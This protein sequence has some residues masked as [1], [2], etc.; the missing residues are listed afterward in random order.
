MDPIT[1]GQAK[2]HTDQKVLE[3]QEALDV[4]T[5]G[6]KW[7]NQPYGNSNVVPKITTLI[8]CQDDETPDLVSCTASVDGE[9]WK[10]NGR[11]WKVEIAGS[12]TAQF[13]MN[14]PAPLETKP[15]QSLCAWVYIEDVSKV[16]VMSFQ[17]Y[18]TADMQTPW[19]ASPTS[20]GYTLKNGWNFFR[21][22]AKYSVPVAI[23]NW[24]NVYRTRIAI[25]TSG[26][27][28]VTI[29]HV[30]LE[31]FDKAKMVVVCD[32]CYSTFLSEV[33]PSLASRNIPV[34]WAVSPGKLGEV[35]YMTEE[36]LLD[37]AKENDNELSFHSWNAEDLEIMTE[38]ELRAESI[39]CIK[40][41]QERG[42]N[43]LWRAAW[44]R[45]NAPNHSA[46]QGLWLA[47]SSPTED[48]SVRTNC[49]PPMNRYNVGRRILHTQTQASL[50]EM[51]AEL[52]LTNGF[53]NLYTHGLS[54]SS[55]DISLDQ[56]NWFLAEV[57]TALAEGWLLPTTVGSLL[58]Q[59]AVL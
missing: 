25:Q 11:G 28:S 43:P 42:Y 18:W 29:G 39:K 19:N 16:D 52:K 10:I 51:F 49:W 8:G 21:I 1:L 46:T 59:H 3:Q 57:D 44:F 7:L 34:T 20:L 22:Q 9:H 4:T 58:R 36:Q 56:L 48:T 53:L 14:P 33:Y 24:N 15:A 27:T 12:V 6:K 30:F 32:G 47:Y 5:F 50:A 41:A 40:W 26:A 54:E 23:T 17:I 35:K 38:A 2:K 31:H 45:N 13:R 55:N 37:V